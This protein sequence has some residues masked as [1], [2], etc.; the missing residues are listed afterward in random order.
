MKDLLG[1][2][3][4][5]REHP[6]HMGEPVHEVEVVAESPTKLTRKV[7][8]RHLQGEYAGLEE[9]VAKASLLVPWAESEAFSRDERAFLEARGDQ[10]DD[11]SSTL[12]YQAVEGVLLSLTGYDVG[13]GWRAS[14]RNLLRIARFEHTAGVL[15][16][17]KAQL[18]AEPRSFI[19][20]HG[21]YWAPFDAAVRLAKWVCDH[22]PRKVLEALR[23]EE[24][25]LHV[26]AV[27]GVEE[28]ER[29]YA[30][31]RIPEDAS[32][33]AQVREWCGGAAA[34]QF[35][36]IKHL[37]DEVTR[38]RGLLESA[39]ALLDSHGHRALAASCGRS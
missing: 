30:S 7:R 12:A 20:R 1:K 28:F 38:L 3:Y 18:M 8:I 6:K 37:Q 5:Y 23:A 24:N 25:R 35:N 11:L 36:E 2:R 19:D 10:T 22:S 15:E 4:A 33:F 21:T 14:E 17:P 29:R 9:W 27:R 34:A 32:V 39:V 31:E 13:F 26:Q 16:L